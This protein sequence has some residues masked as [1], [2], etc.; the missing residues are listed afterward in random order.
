VKRDYSVANTLSSASQ[1]VRSTLM[2]LLPYIVATKET[3]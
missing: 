2:D 3:P 1:V